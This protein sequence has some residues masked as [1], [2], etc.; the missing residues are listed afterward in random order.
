M[1]SLVPEPLR[2]RDAEL[3]EFRLL[4]FRWELELRL[5]VF[6]LELWFR[7]GVRWEREEEPRSSD[8]REAA[9]A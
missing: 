5:L 8:P 1:L 3:L 4:E 7:W 2:N 6:K 9:S